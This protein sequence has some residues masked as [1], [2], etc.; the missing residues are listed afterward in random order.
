MQDQVP[1]KGTSEILICVFKYSVL[2]SR[3]E[4]NIPKS[5]ILNSISNLSFRKRIV[6]SPV[7]GI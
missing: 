7:E 4:D 1:Y 3:Q 6:P 5:A 2:D